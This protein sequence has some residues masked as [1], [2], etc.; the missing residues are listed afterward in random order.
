MSMESTLYFKAL[1]LGFLGFLKAC[2]RFKCHDGMLFWLDGILHICRGA[3]EILSGCLDLRA[4][5][6]RPLV[7]WV[8][9][10]E[11]SSGFY[12]GAWTSGSCALGWQIRVRRQRCCTCLVLA[13]E[14][15]V[16]MYSMYLGF[17]GT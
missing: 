8:T 5:Q 3:S 12:F 13:L 6:K 15:R 2:K 9:G 17:T 1:G 10:H 16:R 4:G 14:L 11:C 7:F